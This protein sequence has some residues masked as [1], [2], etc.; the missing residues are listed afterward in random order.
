MSNAVLSPSPARRSDNHSGT[1]LAAGVALALWLVVVYLLGGSGAFVAQPGTP[2]RA[3]LI[4]VVG[5]VVAFFAAYRASRSFREWA[6]T[7]DLRPIMAIQAWRFAGLGFLALYTH[8]V[9][10][11]SFALPAGLG[12]LAMGLTAPWV[13]VALLRRP[14]F[15]KSATFKLWNVFGILDLVVALGTG[16]LSS[17]LATGKV[18]EVTSGPMA[19]LPLLLIPA[20]LVPILLMLHATALLQARTGAAPRG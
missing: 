11:G 2:P 19:Q 7:A 13:L 16:A 12:D 6:L 3:I 20:Y 9:L 15:A 14:D 10:P 17:A 18:G 4:G 8:G 5:P 1:K